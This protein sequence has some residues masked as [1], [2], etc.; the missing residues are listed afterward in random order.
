MLAE[1]LIKNLVSQ[2]S[3]NV[4]K[5][6]VRAVFNKYIKYISSRG[7]TRNANLYASVIRNQFSAELNQAASALRCCL[8]ENFYDLAIRRLDFLSYRLFFIWP[9]ITRSLFKAAGH[10]HHGSLHS[11]DDKRPTNTRV[12]YRTISLIGIC[13]VWAEQPAFLVPKKS[14]NSRTSCSS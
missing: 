1:V 2:M 4:L 13:Q 6:I 10:V 11:A 12:C 8:N 9:C 3:S 14:K 5:I 7:D